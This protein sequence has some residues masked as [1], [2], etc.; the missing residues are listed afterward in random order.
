M[1][2]TDFTYTTKRSKRRIGA[3]VEPLA[4]M[5]YRG[6]TVPELA[7]DARNMVTALAL[8]CDLLSEP[9]VLRNGYGHYA[10]EL[11]LVAAASRRL[12]EKLMVL[13]QN[14]MVG[15]APV[16]ISLPQNRLPAGTTS[17]AG[18]L[19]ESAIENLEKELLAN[20]D[21]LSAMTGASVHLRVRTEG[22]ALPV[23]LS[24][25]DLTR[26][27]INLVKNASEA[28][29]NAGA[30]DIALREL[31]D[32]G[33]GAVR[34]A[35]RVEDSGPGICEEMLETIF[36]SGYTTRAASCD[37]VSDSGWPLTHHGLGLA[38]TRSLIDA[39]GGTI[40]ACNHPGGG[41][42]FTIELPICS[43]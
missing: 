12:V 4:S 39:A 21:L 40:R 27:L 16:S 31:P 14:E 37:P 22:G 43:A 25:A 32:A 8:Y 26:V 30:I 1:Q 29:R 28:M 34:V 9:G 42:R 24:R 19:P 5:G 2:A 15:S 6:G 35:I 7:H 18:S 3:V 41:A 10:D 17:Q 38:I 11:R 20:R 13:D 33:A 36:E 23:S